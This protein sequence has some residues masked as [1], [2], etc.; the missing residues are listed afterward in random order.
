MNFKTATGDQ[1]SVLNPWESLGYACVSGRI[2]YTAKYKIFEKYIVLMFSWNTELY[3]YMQKKLCLFN[4]DVYKF[5]TILIIWLDDFCVSGT[6]LCALSILYLLVITP[7]LVQLIRS[8]GSMIPK[9]NTV[10]VQAVFSWLIWYF[11]LIYHNGSSI[12][13][14]CNHLLE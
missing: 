5:I 6:Q 3:M 7:E 8:L 13:L 4:K 2:S 11:N 9:S 14:K 1:R 12:L 10:E